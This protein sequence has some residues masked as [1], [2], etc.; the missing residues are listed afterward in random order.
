MI[1]RSDRLQG[2]ESMALS[3]RPT[4][5][6]S[7]HT[8]DES[9]VYSPIAEIASPVNG[10]SSTSSSSSSRIVM[11][12]FPVDQNIQLIPFVSLCPAIKYG[13]FF[14]SLRGR[15]VNKIR[16]VPKVAI[17]NSCAYHRIVFTMSCIILEVPHIPHSCC[18]LMVPEILL[19]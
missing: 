7:N 19:S 9:Y 13:R 11:S 15:G 3:S 12:P 10:A 6:S 17:H 8:V 14:P 2:I 18:V 1:H 5:I 16:T 4:N